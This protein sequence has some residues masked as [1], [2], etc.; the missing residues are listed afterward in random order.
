M[1]RFESIRLALKVEKQSLPRV[2]MVTASPKCNSSHLCHNLLQVA[3]RAVT[4][5]SSPFGLQQ[6]N[7]CN[8]VSSH[9]CFSAASQ[10]WLKGTL[11]VPCSGL[12]CLLEYGQWWLLLL[13]I[14]LTWAFADFGWGVQGS[15]LAWQKT[16]RFY[17]WLNQLSTKTHLLMAFVNLSFSRRKHKAA[18]K[19]TGLGG[20]PPRAVSDMPKGLQG[21]IVL[22]WI[23]C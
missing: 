3:S 13:R 9:W 14:G 6:D 23:E 12:S 8:P 21:I 18:D 1:K 4:K 10:R 15:N 16:M 7:Y 11:S 22:L 20:R 19:N 5:V 17:L 2:S